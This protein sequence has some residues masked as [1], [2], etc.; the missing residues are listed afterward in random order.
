MP[1]TQTSQQVLDRHFLELRCSV[2]DLAAAFDRLERS[3]GFTQ[4]ASDQRLTKLHEA[5][6]ILQSSG[7]DRAERIQ[8]LF[9]DS[10]VPNWQTSMK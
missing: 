6:Q 10:Y 3:D 9:S 4:V 1:T 7:D 5:I 8:M 2:L